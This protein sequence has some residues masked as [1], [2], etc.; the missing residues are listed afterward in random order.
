LIPKN[1]SASPVVD[2]K[3]LLHCGLTNS[4]G[5]IY[6]SFGRDYQA[7]A[8]ATALHDLARHDQRQRIPVRPS[9]N[10]SSGHGHLHR[11]RHCYRGGATYHGRR[12]GRVVALRPIR[13]ISAQP[14]PMS[15]RQA[16][17]LILLLSLGIWA[18]IWGLFA[19]IAHVLNF[20]W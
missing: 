19:V 15:N 1:P 13:E 16:L 12:N 4:N 2:G 18:I 6:Q 17:V 7:G 5:P 14:S 11:L 8:V 9:K 3:D 20:L 10:R